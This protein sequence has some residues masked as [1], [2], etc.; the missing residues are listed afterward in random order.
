ME[1]VGLYDFAAEYEK[2]GE[3]SNGNPIYWERAKPILPNHRVDDP[4]KENKW[5]NYYY[6]LLL[7]CVPVCNE[8]DLIEEAETAKSA[9]EH[10]L[11]QKDELNTH[12]ERMLIARERVQ[13]INEAR[14][15]GEEDATTEPAQEDDDNGPEVAGEATLA[16]ND[17]DDFHQNSDS[18][19]PSLEELVQSLN[20]NQAR[21]YEQVKSHL[22]HQLKHKKK[23]CHCA[24]L[25][26]LHM[27]VS[28]VG[29]YGQV[30]IYQD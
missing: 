23:E 20:T 8:A 21:V 15:D 25:Q 29:K 6:S 1:G 7:L 27:S 13:Q 24:D 17:V 19:G 10:Q 11:E 30:F 3:D 2:C 16:M 18:E 5:E 28:G 26:P 9:F 12:S 14:R 22:K 4:A